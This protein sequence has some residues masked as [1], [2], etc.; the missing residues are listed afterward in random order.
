[1]V[2]FMSKKTVSMRLYTDRLARD[3]FFTGVSVN[4]LYD[5]F[6]PCV[7]IFIIKTGVFC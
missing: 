5:M 6:S 3:F 1:M 7:N 4:C 2:P